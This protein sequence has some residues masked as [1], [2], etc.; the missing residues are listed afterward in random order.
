MIQLKTLNKRI[1]T[2]SLGVFYKSVVNKQYKDISIETNKKFHDRFL[3]IDNKE[4]YR[5]GAIF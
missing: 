4:V 1:A 5:I 3:I 2:K